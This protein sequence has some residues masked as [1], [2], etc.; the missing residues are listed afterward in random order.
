M[1]QGQVSLGEGGEVQRADQDR[2]TAQSAGDVVKC[3]EEDR[4][5]MGDGQEASLGR[6]V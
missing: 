1:G 2:N 5:A 3:S 4:A 6:D